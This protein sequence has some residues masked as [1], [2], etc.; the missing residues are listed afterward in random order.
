MDP[1]DQGEGGD[2]GAVVGLTLRFAL[3]ARPPGSQGFARARPTTK[4]KTKAKARARARTKIERKGD[5]SKE[6]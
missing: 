2:E 1:D 3:N 5:I 4:T 6:L